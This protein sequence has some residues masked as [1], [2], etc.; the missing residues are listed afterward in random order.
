MN[1]VVL[2][3]WH[4][5]YYFIYDF[6]IAQF[7]DAKDLGDI[8]MGSFP[9]GASYAGKGRLKSMTVGK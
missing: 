8:R 6:Y 7:S 1:H 3:V 5:I 9:M 4:F 2:F